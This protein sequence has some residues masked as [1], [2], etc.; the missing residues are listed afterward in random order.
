MRC[1]ARTSDLGLDDVPRRTGL[2]RVRLLVTR[3]E[4]EGGATAARLRARGHEALVAPLLRIEAVTDAVIGAGPWS[5]VIMTSRNAAR[6]IEQHRRV[7]E[8][9]RLPVFTV[10]RSTAAAARAAGFTDVR[11]ADGDAGELVDLILSGGTTPG[12]PLLYLAGVD[13]AADV[14]GDLRAAGLPADTVV[15]Y[16]AVAAQE[17]STSVC[18]AL[19]AGG[20]DGVLHLSR[21]SADIFLACARR[22]GLLDRAL[23][24]THYCLSAQVAEPLVA[25]GARHV[26]VAPRPEESALIGVIP[27]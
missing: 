24:P 11:S 10:G 22:G 20:L 13:R 7:A 9:R 2:S 4:P 18:D 23:A 19:A 26:A 5:G 14:A 27:P 8:L 15:I 6:A 12:G 25:A 17:F 1:N 16:R 21:R 3:P